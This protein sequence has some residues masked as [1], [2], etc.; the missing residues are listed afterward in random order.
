MYVHKLK[1]KNCGVYCS[2][3]NRELKDF[4]MLFAAM[5]IPI[6]C[7]H[8]LLDDK[9]LQATESLKNILHDRPDT[10]KEKKS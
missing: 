2:R 3:C 4:E 5:S 7:S 9:K 8:C 10:E 6:L 1:P